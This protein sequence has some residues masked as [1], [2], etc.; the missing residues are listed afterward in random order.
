LNIAGQINLENKQERGNSLA[1]DNLRT[2]DSKL[3]A[4]YTG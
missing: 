2:L 1:S 4:Q 3:P